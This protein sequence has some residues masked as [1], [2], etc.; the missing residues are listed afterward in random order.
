MRKQGLVKRRVGSTGMAVEESH[1]PAMASHAGTA[2]HGS[3]QEHAH[4]Y[5]GLLLCAPG[6][7]GSPVL[8]AVMQVST[9]FVARMGRG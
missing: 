8:L 9:A 1:A 5:P 2:Q 6:K 3:L 4:W 7:A